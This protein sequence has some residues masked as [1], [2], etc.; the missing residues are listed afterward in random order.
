MIIIT[1]VGKETDL[2]LKSQNRLF[3]I[4]LQQ[5]RCN[6]LRVE[7]WLT[8]YL[9]LNV[10]FVAVLNRNGPMDNIS[11]RRLSSLRKRI[12]PTCKAVEKG[13]VHFWDLATGD[14]KFV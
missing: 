5:H 13:N 12:L 9:I 14:W 6:Y 10:I 4:K 2:A 11:G 3:Q 1:K 8:T 7:G